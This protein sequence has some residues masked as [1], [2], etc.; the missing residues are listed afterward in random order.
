M[1]NQGFSQEEAIALFK[2][3]DEAKFDVGLSVSHTERMVPSFNYSVGVSVGPGRIVSA[4][5]LAQLIAITERHDAG[6]H[7]IGNGISIFKNN[8]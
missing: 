4:E 5:R 7:L 1:M 3:L 2:A 6:C 8:G